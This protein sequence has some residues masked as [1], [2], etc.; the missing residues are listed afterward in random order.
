MIKLSENFQLKEKKYVTKLFPHRFCCIQR[1]HFRDL[2]RYWKPEGLE[3][4]TPSR[5]PL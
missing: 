5:D 2:S 4:S 3:V 1:L